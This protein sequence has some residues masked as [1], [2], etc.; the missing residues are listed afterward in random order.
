MVKLR[1]K[2]RLRRK[3]W[4]PLGC[5]TA[6]VLLLN[7][8]HEREPHYQGRSLSEWLV[9]LNG[10]YSNEPDISLHDA[11]EAIRHFGT[12]A[13]PFLIKWIQYEEKPWRTHLRTICDK[14]PD[15]FDRHFRKFVDGHGYECQQGALSALFLLGPD[16][17]PAIPALTMVTQT[18]LYPGPYSVV[19]LA[20]LGDPALPSVLTVLTNPAYA[21]ATRVEAIYE[22]G[23]SWTQFTSTQAV[24]SALAA[25]L[26]D[27]DGRVVIT[28]AS[29]LCSTSN[30]QDLA[31]K[32]LQTLTQGSDKVLAQESMSQ[33]RKSLGDVYFVS[34]LIE[35]LHDTNSTMA[36]YAAEAMGELAVTKITLRD[37]VIP[38]LTNSL[39]DPRPLVRGTAAGGLGRLGAAAEPLA[40]AL[41][42]LW[43]DP[44]KRVRQ[45][46]TNAFFQ[47]PAYA[48]LRQAD[49]L[50]PLPVGMNDEQTALYKK[51]WPDSSALVRLLD[52]P[53]L[54][55]REMATNAF[56]KFKEV[57]GEN[58]TAQIPKRQE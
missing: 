18:N 53:D 6:I 1:D 7:L 32:A 37:T 13:L 54:R 33:L 47:L 30:H 36:P 22:I 11:E 15:P 49:Q 29:V 17:I 3:L 52:H 41:L 24:A 44:D 2:G 48:V 50:T 23:K 27:N 16:A 12:N 10:G 19:V 57:S 45:T 14:L 34:R 9:L 8:S 25:C 5:G 56:R 39:R 35:F 58:P 42:D 40:P 20:H 28:A 38:A 55:V 21:S 4:I 51:Y 43:N 46:A 31:I 26:E